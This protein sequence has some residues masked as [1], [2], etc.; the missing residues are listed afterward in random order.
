[1]PILPV[2]DL[3]QGQIVRGV[4]G[5]RAEYR[6]IESGLVRSTDPVA[7]AL[8]LQKQFGFDEF[9]L[10]DLD[11][12][13][14]GEPNLAVYRELQMEGFRLWVDAGLRGRHSTA[15]KMLIIANVSRII[16]GLE[17]ID[18]PDDMSHIVHRLG[19][20]RAVFSLD[21][22]EGKPLCRSANW[23]TDDPFAIARRAIEGM[24][25]RRLI[26]LDLARV[27]VATG[28]GTEELCARIK[29]AYPDVMLIAGGGVRNIDDVKRL[30]GLG[31]EHILVASALHDGRIAPADMPI[32]EP[33]A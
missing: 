16:I 7:V 29:Q 3:M 22:K 25:L 9:Y 18:D 6:P 30:R 10:A 1:M 15:L 31:V 8:A 11:A 28:A 17:T 26:V 5:R 20:D 19:A 4:A 12:I 21:L 27:G 23:H 13:K 32:S 33:E 2:L 14:D 24:G